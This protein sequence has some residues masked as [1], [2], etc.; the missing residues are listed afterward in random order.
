MVFDGVLNDW[1]TQSVVLEDAQFGFRPGLST[2]SAILVLK[3]TVR[4]YTDRNTPVY[5]AFLDLSRAFDLVN[6]GKLWDKLRREGLPEGVN[7]FKYWYHHQ[8]NQVR[9]S[10]T[11]SEAYRLG[12]GVR[13]GGLSSPTL[14]NIYVKELVRELNNTGVGCSIDG[15]IVNNISYADDMVLLS[16]SIS[17]LRKLLKVC[18]VYAEEHGLKYN[19]KKSELLVFR[20]KRMNASCVPPVTL[21]GVAL[22]QVTQFVYLGHVVNE[23]LTDDLDVERERRGLTIRCNMLARRFARCSKPV[24]TTLFRAYCQTFYTC[25][26]WTSNTQR[27]VSALRIQYNNAF[28]LLMGL[29]RY[30]SASAMF[31]ESNI[32]GFHAIIRKRVASLMRRVR[33]SSNSYLRLIASLVYEAFCVQDLSELLECRELRWPWYTRAPEDMSGN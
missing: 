6:Y 14:F 18:E 7:I 9:W 33:D 10:G 27:V 25:S 22:H 15:Q 5:A 20:A 12:C 1:L 29:P 30:C 21:G 17:A 4:Y 31:A 24:K 16:P 8:T 11:F 26:L 3:H 28:R 2:E 19:A 23:E 13:Q 32:D